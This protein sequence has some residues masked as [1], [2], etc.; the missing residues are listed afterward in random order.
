MDGSDY[1]SSETELP[2][3][4][5]PPDP[6]RQVFQLT[7]AFQQ[8]T[9]QGAES[10]YMDTY[11]RGQKKRKKNPRPP[12]SDPN[13]SPRPATVPP[14][15]R[16][17]AAIPPPPSGF[18][19]TVMM[20]PQHPSSQPDHNPP[21][22]QPPPPTF[23]AAPTNPSHSP[24]VLR[25]PTAPELSTTEEQVQQAMRQIIITQVALS[26]FQY[27][28]AVTTQQLANH[29]MMFTAACSHLGLRR[30]SELINISA[31]QPYQALTRAAE[32]CSSD[33]LT[34]FPPTRRHLTAFQQGF[35]ET[36]SHLKE[37]NTQTAS[38]GNM[39]ARTPSIDPLDLEFSDLDLIDP[40]EERRPPTKKRPGALAT[41]TL[42]RPPQSR[43]TTPNTPRLPE[44]P[45]GIHDPASGMNPFS[46]GATAS[47]ATLLTTFGEF[48]TP[49]SRYPQSQNSKRPP[50][51]DL[52]CTMAL[53][54]ASTI[55]PEK[56]MSD[57]YRK[58]AVVSCQGLTIYSS[59]PIVNRPLC[60]TNDQHRAAREAYLKY[61]ETAFPTDPTYAML[62]PNL[63]T[64]YRMTEKDHINY[65]IWLLSYVR[66]KSPYNHVLSLPT[67]GIFAQMMGADLIKFEKALAKYKLP[68][69]YKT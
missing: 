69:K 27:C 8:A 21:A 41:A 35:K 4:E 68:Q 56:N 59:H 5:T 11:N 54:K 28:V 23:T 40:A 29:L 50:C 13:Q 20:S 49:E 15:S 66:Y 64:L 39:G 22:R 14:M 45:P 30:F 61:V 57:V 42:S 17:Q 2:P 46:G 24:R 3:E 62:A 37:V 67:A 33:R 44:T 1:S 38:A 16:P 6:S 25:S 18:E 19:D 55:L 36:V 47:D 60:V 51:T 63:E 31:V 65:G 58:G 43:P 52:I 53:D 32:N 12:S 7:Q 10:N 34:L 9:R 48:R 26:Y